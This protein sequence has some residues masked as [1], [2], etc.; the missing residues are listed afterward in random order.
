MNWSPETGSQSIALLY[1]IL[2]LAFNLHEAFP[3]CLENPRYAIKGFIAHN[4]VHYFCFV[5]QKRRGLD[6]WRYYSD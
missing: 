6:V 1:A 4:G 3:N 2:P 5:R